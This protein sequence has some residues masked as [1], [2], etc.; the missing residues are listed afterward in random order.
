M[1]NILLLCLGRHP[2]Q[3]PHY[4]KPDIDKLPKSVVDQIPLVLYIPPPP[5]ETTD[6]TPSIPTPAPAHAYPP[7]SPAPSSTAPKRRFM[8][9]RRKDAKSKNNKGTGHSSAADAK[10]LRDKDGKDEKDAAVAAEEQEQEEGDVPWDE[11]WEKSEYPFVRLEG[12]RAVCAICLMDFEEPKRVRGA[13]GSGAKPGA[14]AGSGPS[15]PPVGGG[16]ASGSGG[17][18]GEATQEIQVEAVT[19]EERDALGEGQGEGEGEGPE[20]LRLLTCG[21]VFHV[22]SPCSLFLACATT[23]NADRV[24][25]CSGWG[26]AT[27]NVLGPVA[28]GR[29]RAVPYL[30]AAG[31][32]PRADEEVEGEAA[33]KDIVRRLCCA[34]CLLSF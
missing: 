14:D 11:M 12:N 21:H 7:K 15:S 3:N 6:T 10:A 33:A 26:V 27:E 1:Y 22:S 2:L 9:F 32:G 28:D 31:G 34:D 25:F 5:G 18:R 17:A 8:F 4:I 19:E 13:K 20:P 16:G 23:G 30:P 29:V 24:L